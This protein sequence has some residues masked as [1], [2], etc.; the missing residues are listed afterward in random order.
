MSIEVVSPPP[1]ALPVPRTADVRSWLVIA[2]VAILVAGS[3][4][5]SK[6]VGD[7]AYLWLILREAPEE[8]TRGNA[9]RGVM[10]AIF[11]AAADTGWFWEIGFVASVAASLATAAAARGLWMRLFPQ[12]APYWASAA[13][14]AAAPIVFEMQALLTPVYQVQCAAVFLVG[15]TFLRRDDRVVGLL[16]GLVAA[17]LTA[18]LG[19]VTEYT[20]S[21]GAALLVLLA[22]RFEPLSSERRRAR[23]VGAAA[24]SVGLIAGYAA[25]RYFAATELRPALEIRGNLEHFMR[26]SWTVPFKLLQALGQVFGTALGRDVTAIDLMSKIG[27][28]A[29]LGGAAAAWIAAVDMRRRLGMHRHAE[30]MTTE[31]GLAKALFGIAVAVVVA[32]LPLLVMDR[33]PDDEGPASRYFAGIVPLGGCATLGLLLLLVRPSW[34]TGAA[35]A[36]AGLAAAVALHDAGR[37]YRERGLLDSAGTELRP[38]VTGRLT[39]IFADFSA[40]P[41][42]G[43]GGSYHDVELTARLT[44]LWNDEERRRVWVL[45]PDGLVGTPESEP[46]FHRELFVADSPNEPWRFNYHLRGLRRSGE[47]DRVLLA[48]FAKSGDVRLLD[49]R[50]GRVLRHEKE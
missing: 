8:V 42:R 47:V 14:L 48:I 5:A 32:L 30:P 10:G 40:T 41:Y 44:R 28:P 18:V 31:S 1:H 3:A 24:L 34:R 9:D 21:A 35:V 43:F 7:D 20:L 23:Y 46:L 15:S 50:S 12:F 45:P 27:P 16:P 49:L 37:W 39:L 38:H 25:Y 11:Q 4:Y 6:P 19:C 36:A 33:R 26:R 17:A 2:T 13:L 29:V 22:F